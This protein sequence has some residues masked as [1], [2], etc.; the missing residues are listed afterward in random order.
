MFKMEMGAGLHVFS[1]LSWPADA[2]SAADELTADWLRHHYTP[3]PGSFKYF[4]SIATGFLCVFS[5]Q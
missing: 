5:L 4:I 1:G 3:A 2:R